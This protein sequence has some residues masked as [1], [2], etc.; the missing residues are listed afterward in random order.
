MSNFYDG[1]LG[2]WDDEQRQRAE[3]RK[4]IHEEELE[5]VRTKQDY[6]A[7]LAVAR[8]NGFITAGATMFA[9][10]PKGWHTGKHSHGEEG[11][12]IID[13]EGFTVLDG[14]RYDWDTGSCLFMP[15]GLVHQHFNSGDRTVRYLS[16]MQLALETFASL[17]KVIQYEEPAENY[18]DSSALL[19]GQRQSGIVEKDESD[20]HPEYGRIVLRLKD[21]PV[22]ISKDVDRTKM[23]AE[24]REKA[25]NLVGVFHN[26]RWVH[27]MGRNSNFANKEVRLSGFLCHDSGMFSGKHRHQ[28]AVLYVVQGEGYSI[29]DGNKIE[30]KKGTMF[31]V[32]G[33]QTVHQHF[34]T[35]KVEDQLLRI[36]YGL[37]E[38]FDTII[39]PHHVDYIPDDFSP[40]DETK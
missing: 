37:R 2:L 36:N 14:K 15:Y 20:V 21:A 13:G 33:P 26:T 19:Y 18:I 28:E 11:I 6:R 34:N 22:V 32:Q 17:A 39:L 12:F 29:V 24:D 9:E 5:W 1:W 30:W 38:Y 7:A 4:V 35:G 25:D 16:V 31:H 8:E 3:A 23:S 10:I 40:L 27:L